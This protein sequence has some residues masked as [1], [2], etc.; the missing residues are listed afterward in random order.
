M[1]PKVLLY[2]HCKRFDYVIFNNNLPKQTENW[3]FD[4]LDSATTTKIFMEILDKFSPLKKKYIGANHSKV[5]TKEV[6]KA[7]CWDQN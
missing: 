4:E 6:S 5:V 2:R 1:L 7:I 3:N